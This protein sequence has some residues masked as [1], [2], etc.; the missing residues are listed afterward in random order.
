MDDSQCCWV[1]NLTSHMGSMPALAGRDKTQQG[2]YRG[3]G[4]VR[5]ATMNAAWLAHASHMGS[6]PSLAA[7]E[8]MR[9]LD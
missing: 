8:G 4:L 6:R 2:L 7:P 1:K 5:W 3:A 9:S